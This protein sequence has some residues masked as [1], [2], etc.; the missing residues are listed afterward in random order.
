MNTSA[1]ALKIVAFAIARND[2]T[3]SSRCTVT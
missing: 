2:F 3:A 1:M